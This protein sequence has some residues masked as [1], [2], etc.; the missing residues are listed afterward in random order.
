M[1]VI[2]FGLAVTPDEKRLFVTEAGINAVGVIDLPT[3]KVIG[4]IMTG[5]FP[6]K[7]KITPDGKNIVVTNAKGYGSRPNGRK[8]FK[9]GREGTYIDN[10]GYLI[11]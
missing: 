4:H 6:S 3:F 8:N 9:E 7:L 1:A 5:W 11:F 10:L 2:P